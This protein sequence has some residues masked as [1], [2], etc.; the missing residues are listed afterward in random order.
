[1]KAL[2]EAIGGTALAW[3]SGAAMLFAADHDAVFT[4]LIEGVVKIVAIIQGV[5]LAYLAYLQYS[6]RVAIKTNTEALD[7]STKITTAFA[8]DAKKNVAELKDTV[9]ATDVAKSEKLEEVKQTLADQ[10]SRMEHAASSMGKVEVKM[11]EIHVLVNDQR[12]ARIAYIQLLRDTLAAH[13][14]PVPPRPSLL[15]KLDE[16]PSP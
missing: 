13:G 3:A 1:M 8:V 16:A 10:N 15:V 14:V 7:K 2:C 12:A 11:E 9:H 4:T 6:T 5:I